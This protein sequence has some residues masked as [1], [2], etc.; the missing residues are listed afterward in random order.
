MEQL[1]DFGW[2]YKAP[3]DFEHKQWTLFAYLKKVDDAFCNKVFSPYLLHTEKLAEDMSVS[4]DFIQSFEKGITKRG[5][6][7]QMEGLYKVD[8]PPDRPEDFSTIIEV[9][10][11][12]IPLMNQ[13]V[14]LGNKLIKKF[15][16]IVLHSRL[17]N[18]Q[19]RD[20]IS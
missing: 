9:I 5:L 17:D 12:S 18:W 3:Y 16:N 11:F 19:R 14:E 1:L 6:L 8:T 15:P 4:L 2:Y 13:R 10:E 20:D 7:F